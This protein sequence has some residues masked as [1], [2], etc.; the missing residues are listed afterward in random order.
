M[1]FFFLSENDD[2][3]K[4][5]QIVVVLTQNLYAVPIFSKADYFR[6]GTQDITGESKTARGT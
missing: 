5:E 2:D 3:P 4:G 6:D 1:C